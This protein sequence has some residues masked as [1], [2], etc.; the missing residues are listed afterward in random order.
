MN[1]GTGILIRRK[2][3]LMMIQHEMATKRG[4]T[5]GEFIS[6]EFSKSMIEV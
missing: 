6:V 4:W 1:T 3:H 5:I 2:K